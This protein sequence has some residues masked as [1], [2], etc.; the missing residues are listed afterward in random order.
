MAL[1]KV[2]TYP[3]MAPAQADDSVR[4][5]FYVSWAPF[6]WVFLLIKVLTGWRQVMKMAPLLRRGSRAVKGIR[7]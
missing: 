3:R 1:L 4:E 2:A 7:L 5:R 6:K